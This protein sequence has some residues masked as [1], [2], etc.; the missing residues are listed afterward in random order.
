MAKLPDDTDLLFVYGTLLPGK[1]SPLKD[2]ILEACEIVGEGWIQGKL[3]TLEGYPGLIETSDSRHNVNGVILKLRDPS[4]NL[5]VIDN[6]EEIGP[7]YPVPQEY[8][9][10]KRKVHTSGGIKICWVYIYNLRETNP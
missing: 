3:I 9:R 8:I 10:V 4:D 1:E 7:N 6:Y 5:K 2:Y